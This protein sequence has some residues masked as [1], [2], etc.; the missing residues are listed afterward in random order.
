MKRPPKN[1]APR[2]LTHGQRS[3]LAAKATYVGSPEHK[4]QKWWDGRPEARQLP[5]GRVGR[6][7]K[8]TTTVCPLTSQEDR[9]RATTWVRRAIMMDQCKFSQADKDYPKK[10]WYEEDGQ[11]WFGRCINSQAGQ[12]KGWPIDEEER[13]AI[14]D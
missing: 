12:Y 3:E 7:G 13:R 1:T 9:D 5:G 11:I 14:F 4:V 8:Q 2:Q 6:P 10:I